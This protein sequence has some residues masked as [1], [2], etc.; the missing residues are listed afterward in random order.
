MTNPKPN[1]VSATG[2]RLSRSKPT[3]IQ[4]AA[5]RAIWEG[6]PNVSFENI[7]ESLNVSRS[8]VS[9]QAGRNGWTKRPPSE[10]IADQAQ[11]AADSKFEQEQRD[12][13]AQSAPE[14]AHVV[15]GDSENSP[16]PVRRAIPAP[17]SVVP[18]VPAGVTEEEAKRAAVATA[19][20]RRAEVLNTHRKEWTAVRTLAYASIK[21]KDIEGA[22]HVKVVA[23]SLKIVQ[24][25]ERK[26]WGL[27]RDEN[28]PP[29]VSITVNRRAG[30]T[31]GH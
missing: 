19:I 28:K 3:R 5:A 7:A 8:A 29:S 27:D 13:A 15:N 12:K 16:P 1:F 31:I 6:D 4:W 21:A 9:M 22:K 2:K 14:P 17:A 25:G 18:E 24:D 23:E 10:T 30:V 20:E 26:A 11:V